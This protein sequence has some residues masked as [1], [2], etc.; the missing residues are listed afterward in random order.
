MADKGRQIGPG[1]TDSAPRMEDYP[2]GSLQS[3]AAAR[4][5]LERRFAG[6]KRFE[7]VTRPIVDD[8]D[9]VEPRVG[10]W[11]EGLDGTLWRHSYLPARMS[12][13]EAERI[14]S[15]PGLKQSTQ[16]DEAPS[17]GRPVTPSW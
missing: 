1:A 5:M 16:N 7:I 6:R 12:I 14:A 9:F 10:E 17:G 2:I 8:P 13:K 3:R 15:Q 4:A 11:R